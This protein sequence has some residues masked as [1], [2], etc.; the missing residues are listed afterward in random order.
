MSQETT[1]KPSKEYVI[2]HSDGFVQGWNLAIAEVLRVLE[3]RLDIVNL[4]GRDPA[5]IRI[6]TRAVKQMSDK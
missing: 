5:E 4:L 6:I 1:E 2:A 3:E